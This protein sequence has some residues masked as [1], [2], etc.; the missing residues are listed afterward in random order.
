MSQKDLKRLKVLEQAAGKKIKQRKAAEWLG[1]SGRQVRR[2]IKRMRKEGAKGLVHRLRG[3]Q[4]NRRY[5]DIF[6]EKVLGK[7]RQ[8]YD[9][10]GPTLAQEKL[11]EREKIK[12]SRE[13]LRKWLIA[14]GWWKKRRHVSEQHQWRERKECYGEMVQADGSHHD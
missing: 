13:T 8:K 1:I 3:R 9:G 10:F 5:G 11:E 6:K 4:S 2:L 12:V 14:E 7:Y